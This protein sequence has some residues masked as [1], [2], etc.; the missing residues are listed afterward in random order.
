MTIYGYA[1]V[2]TTEQD[3]EI[4]QEALTGTECTSIKAEKISGTL[5]TQEREQLR[6]L[7]EYIQEGDVLVVTRIDRLARSIADLQQIIGTQG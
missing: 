6:T 1:R 4:Q 5:G 7:L 3:L 2:S